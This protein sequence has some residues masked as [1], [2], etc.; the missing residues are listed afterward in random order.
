MLFSAASL[1]EITPITSQ[2]SVDTLPAIH[3]IHSIRLLVAH[4]LCEG[5]TLL[6]GDAQL[7]IEPEGS[8]LQLAIFNRIQPLHSPLYDP[9]C[10]K[11]NYCEKRK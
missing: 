9:I 3:M 7:A 5:V 10:M 4:A 8:P 1:W 6:S 11:W 2:L